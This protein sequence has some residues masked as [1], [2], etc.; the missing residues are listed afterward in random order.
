MISPYCFTPGWS[1]VFP[2]A[3]QKRHLKRCFF[4]WLGLWLPMKVSRLRAGRPLRSNVV[5]TCGSPTN[6]PSLTMEGKWAGK[7]KVFPSAIKWE[8]FRLDAD[9]P[10][11]DRSFPGFCVPNFS[12]ET[13]DRLW[14]ISGTGMT[15][16]FCFQKKSQRPFWFC[17][18]KKGLFLYTQKFIAAKK[19]APVRW[20]GIPVD[21]CLL[22]FSK[23]KLLT[24]KEDSKGKG[25]IPY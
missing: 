3:K 9:K 23:I 10:A 12:S 22:R 20:F 6:A 5:G 1:K 8:H 17:K 14:P 11:S 21:R 13:K 18:I 24:I 2:P 25:V 16:T 7:S 19:E 4:V 15:R